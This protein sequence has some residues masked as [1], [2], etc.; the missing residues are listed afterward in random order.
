MSL[1][2]TQSTSISRSSPRQPVASPATPQTGTAN[3]YD[4]CKVYI[5]AEPT[6]SS[7][8][9]QVTDCFKRSHISQETNPAAATHYFLFITD[10]FIKSKEHVL[11]LIAKLADPHFKQR[12][13]PVIMDKMSIFSAGGE[14]GYVEY[15]NEILKKTDQN[16]PDYGD[17]QRIKENI[18]PFICALRDTLMPPLDE[19]LKADLKPII[20]TIEKRAY[21][22]GAKRFFFLPKEDASHFI[23]QETAIAQISSLFANKSAVTLTGEAGTGKTSLAIEYAKRADAYPNGIFWFDASDEQSLEESYRQLGVQLGMNAIQI[24]RE[25]PNFKNCL[26]IYDN[27]PDSFA[28]SPIP[29]AHTLIIGSQL[30]SP[31][32]TLKSLSEENAAQ[33][34]TEQ[35]G[36]TSDDARA[37]AKLMENHPAKLSSAVTYIKSSK[38]SVQDYINYY[39][40]DR[41]NLLA[42]QNASQKAKVSTAVT[43]STQLSTNVDPTPATVSKY[44]NQSVE[45]LSRGLKDQGIQIFVSYNWGAKNEVEQLDNAFKD[46]GIE[47]LRD[48][49][50]LKSFDSIREFMKKVIRQ[51]DYTF[52]VITGPYLKSFNCLFEIITTMQDPYWRSLVFPLVL[53]GTDLSEKAILSYQE[54]WQQEAERLERSGGTSAEIAIAKEG[55]QKIAAYL[56]FVVQTMPKPFTHQLN[57]RFQRTLA[58]M[59]A[60]QEKLEKKGIYKQAIFH[61]PMGRNKDFTGRNREMTLLEESLKKG[62]YSAITNTG[63]G[64]VGKSQLALEYAYRHEKEYEML[65]WIRSEDMGTIKSDLRMLGLEMGIAEDFLK[66]DLVISTMKGVLEKRKGWLLVF[67]NA[68]DPK[69]LAAVMPQRGGHIIVTSRNKNWDRSVSV[70]VFSKEEALRYLQKISGVSGQEEELKLLA[71]ELGYLPLALTQAGAYIR[72]QQIDVATYRVAYKEGQKN[73]LSQKEKGYPGSVATAWLIEHGKNC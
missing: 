31:D 9:G 35:L 18:S 67:D 51:A 50:E 57:T 52:S 71:E 25:L 17:I 24:K 38:M 73:L 63:M 53:P 54:H 26:L 5:G 65:Y 23:G 21:L 30:S 1:Q 66:D 6:F 42:K 62:Q 60:R 28:I 8:A 11:P 13:F 41:D 20:D 70:D 44:N 72:R 45:E 68:E 2:L 12:L 39:T 56:R 47:L 36:S 61:L 59:L 55:A 3:P 64:G 37:L 19:L 33:F 27:V 15:W 16:S 14:L 7:Q 49:R 4:G 43:P 34:V 69:A 58:L 32:I 29:H 46:L 10:S 48:A 40:K 22:Y